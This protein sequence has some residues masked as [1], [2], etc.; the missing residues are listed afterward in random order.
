MKQKPN[1]G[2]RKKFK[3]MSRIFLT[4]FCQM[5]LTFHGVTM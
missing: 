5:P 4:K 3:N 2:G 1:F